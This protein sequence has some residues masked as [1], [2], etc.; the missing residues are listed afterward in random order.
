MSTVAV[1]VPVSHDRAAA[2]RG[3]GDLGVTAAHAVGPA[4]RQA[5]GLGPADDEEGGFVALGYAGLTALLDHPGPRLVL[6]ADV[7]AG[8]VSGPVGSFGEVGVRGLRWDQVTAVFADEPSAAGELEAARSLA[9]GRPLSE[10]ADDEDVVALVDRWDLL[11]FA[12]SELDA[13][14]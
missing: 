3:G 10:V 6:A 7:D 8:Q 12:P 13:V 5:H 14:S 1:F 9:G 2:L 11:W 4:L